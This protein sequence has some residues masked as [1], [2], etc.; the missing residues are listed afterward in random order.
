M[1]S[2]H[3][4]F[5]AEAIGKFKRM[6]V[7]RDRCKCRDDDEYLCDACSELTDLDEALRRELIHTPWGGHPAVVWPDHAPRCPQGTLGR[8][9][10]DRDGPKL[11]RALCQAAGEQGT[12]S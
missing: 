4:R 11:F 10:E 2:R 6:M 7:L 5:S 9:W 8:E 1:M 3:R 12:G